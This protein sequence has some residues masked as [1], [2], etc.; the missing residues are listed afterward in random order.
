MPKNI[1]ENRKLL[2]YCYSE[3]NYSIIIH[4]VC[5]KKESHL[6]PWLSIL[7]FCLPSFFHTFPSSPLR[8]SVRSTPPGSR[9]GKAGKPVRLGLI[10]GVGTPWWP[11]S[12]LQ[13]LHFCLPAGEQ[14]FCACPP[15]PFLSLLPV[16]KTVRESNSGCVSVC[17][18]CVYEWLRVTEGMRKH[19]PSAVWHCSLPLLLLPCKCVWICFFPIIKIKSNVWLLNKS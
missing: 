15:P 13:L 7:L 1:W 12:G 19:V 14:S 17:P 5:V 3:Q 9:I 2:F 6:P 18:A 11:R 10:L 16:W 4:N 8:L